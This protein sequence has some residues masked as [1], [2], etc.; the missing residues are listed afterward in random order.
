MPKIIG[1]AE[2]VVDIAGILSIDEYVGNI[3]SHQDDLSIARVQISQPTLEPW[4]TLDYDEWMVVL[5]GFLEIHYYPTADNDNKH[6]LTVR[7]GE[8]VF[9]PKGE[10]FQPVF[11][12]AGAEYI[13]VCIPAFRPD[14]CLR[15]GE[16]EKDGVAEN[17]TRLHLEAAAAATVNTPTK[18][19]EPT[20][21]SVATKIT[22]ADTTKVVYHMCQKVLWDKAVESAQA[23]FPPTFQQDGFFTHATAVP[24]RLLETANHFYTATEG[25]WICLELS[26]VRLQQVAGIMTLF[27]EPKPVGDQTVSPE[28]HTNAWACPH[29]YGGIPTM[30]VGS[31]HD[32]VTKIFDM[33]RDAESGTFLSIV[34]LTDL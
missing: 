3:G 27:E 13:P 15:E 32:I 20:T 4:L 17:L 18:E 22:V 16:E 19:D 24:T 31:D 21:S 12:Q 30:S 2:R 33:K 1:K 11:P 26:V 28:W 29:I 25:S 6:V 8:T 7:E 23:Y 9:I 34:G 5:K 14:R 10:R